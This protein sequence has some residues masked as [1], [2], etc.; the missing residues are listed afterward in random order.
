MNCLKCKKEIEIG[1][2]FDCASKLN[3]ATNDRTEFDNVIA[4]WKNRMDIDEIVGLPWRI[5]KEMID[6][7]YKLRGADL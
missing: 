2:C 5:I 1:I 3:Q 4:K 7:L 6:D